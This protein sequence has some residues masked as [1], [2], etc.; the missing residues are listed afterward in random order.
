MNE[1]EELLTVD[2]LAK[3]LHTPPSWVYSRTRQ[4]GPDSIPVIQ[5]G[6]YKRFI[7][8]NVLAW[9]EKQQGDR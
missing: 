6:K 9:L 7:F 1:N 8:S 3:K 4:T 5:V 2:E